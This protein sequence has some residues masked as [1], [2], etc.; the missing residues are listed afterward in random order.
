MKIYRLVHTWSR[1]L[2]D[3]LRRREGW[4][5]SSSGKTKFNIELAKSLKSKFNVVTCFFVT[6]ESSLAH[7]KSIADGAIDEFEFISYGKQPLPLSELIQKQNILRSDTVFQLDG[8][9]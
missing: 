6:N 1:W 4:L 8:S 9:S 5:Y 7:L 2:N 3:K